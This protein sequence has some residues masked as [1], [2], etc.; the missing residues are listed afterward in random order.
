MNNYKREIFM[1]WL[2]HELS[3]QLNQSGIWARLGTNLQWLQLHCEEGFSF[4]SSDLEPE[5]VET[6]ISSMRFKSHQKI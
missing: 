6:C 1:I 2:S 5:N 4:H 3:D